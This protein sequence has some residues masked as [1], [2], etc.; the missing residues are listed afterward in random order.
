MSNNDADILTNYSIEARYPDDFYLP[1]IEESN[2]AI[3]SHRM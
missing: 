1:S 2:Q 3:I